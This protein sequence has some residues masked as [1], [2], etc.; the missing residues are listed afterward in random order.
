MVDDILGLYPKA[1]CQKLMYLKD[2]FVFEKDMAV[3]CVECVL[4]DHDET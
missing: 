1:V 2:P 3:G 4:A